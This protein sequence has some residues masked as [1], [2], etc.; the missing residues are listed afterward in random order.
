MRSVGKKRILYAPQIGIG[1]LIFSTPLLHSL[2]KAYPSYEITVPVISL[3]QKLASQSLIHLYR[4]LINFHYSIIDE[5]LDK[6]RREIYRSDDFVGKFASEFEKRIIFEKK[7][8]EFYLKGESF[9]LAILPRKFKINSILCPK[10]INLDDLLYIKR[11]HTVERNLRFADY[12][13][14]EKIMSFELDLNQNKGVI[15][16]CGENISLPEKIVT[17]ILSAGRSGKKWTI[18]GHRVVSDFIR[19]RGYMPVLIGS[20]CE[21]EESK[22]IENAGTLNLV[23]KNSFFMDLDNSARFLALSNVVIGGDTG[24]THLADAVGIKVISLYGPNR[25][26]KSAPYNNRDLVISTNDSTKKISDISPS[27]V[28]SKLEDLL[29]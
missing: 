20:P 22:S 16:S 14:I 10:Q 4:N 9:S 15:S 18:E 5:S 24:L 17:I 25:P 2:K 7:V 26:Y 1:D 8:L 19:S 23:R 27:Q 28:I 21:Y 12:L 11:S 13:G 29:V 6:E 3:E